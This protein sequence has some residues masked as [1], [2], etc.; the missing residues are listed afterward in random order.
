MWAYPLIG[1]GLGGMAGGIGAGLMAL[2]L[3][4]GLAAAAALASL[5]LATGALH[6]DGLADSADALGGGR[7]R[8]AVLRILKDSRIGAYGSAAL[9]LALL[10]RW[11]ALGALT[12]GGLVLGLVTA[13]AL[14]RAVMGAAFVALPP[15]RPDGL[16]ATLGTPSWGSAALGLGVALGVAALCLG[17]AALPVVLVACLIPLPLLAYARRRIGGVTGDILGAAQ[18]CAEIGALAMLTLVMGAP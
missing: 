11:S 16:A 13:G 18:Q 7:D 8:E 10:A 4:P 15:A 2:G 9:T 6:E 14:S 12:P 17:A 5:V 3:A 1:A